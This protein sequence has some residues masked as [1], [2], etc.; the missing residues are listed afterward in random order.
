MQTITYD[1]ATHVLV[2]R[3]PTTKMLTAG[4][5]ATD[6]YSHSP[7]GIWAAMLAA[8]PAAP[9]SSCS[10]NSSNCREALK[11]AAA[12]LDAIVKIKRF[13]EADILEL[14]GGEQKSV[15]EILGMANAALEPKS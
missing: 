15:G 5:D 11:W 10:N 12:A 2:P 7:R 4:A 14:D 6:L 1:P 3:D 13:P 8:V 9:Q